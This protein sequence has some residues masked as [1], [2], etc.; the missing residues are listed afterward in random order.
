RVPHRL[1]V[2]ERKSP[3]GSSDSSAVN[4][5]SDLIHV[6]FSSAAAPGVPSEPS[7]GLHARGGGGSLRTG[8]PCLALYWEDNKY[9]HAVVHDMHPTQPTA[10][11]MFADY[12]NYEE[13]LI[14][15]IKPLITGAQVAGR[16]GAV[17]RGSVA[18]RR[19]GGG[20]EEEEETAA[21]SRRSARPTVQY[22]KPPPSRR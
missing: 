6:G 16:H 11:V 14:K 12:G 5:V 20:G 4:K 7:D 21:S 8:D 19:R 2:W 13:V 3:H 18:G 17:G 10:V 22:Y 15:N 9:Y 1:T